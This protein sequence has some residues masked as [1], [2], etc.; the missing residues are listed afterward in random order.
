MFVVPLDICRQE[1][2]LACPRGLRRRLDRRTIVGISGFEI[3]VLALGTIMVP[4]SPEMRVGPLLRRGPLDG[5]AVQ[6]PIAEFK[7]FF[8][9]LRFVVYVG[10]RQGRFGGGVALP[11]D[12]RRD[13]FARLG[14][15]DQ[16]SQCQLKS[17]RRQ[18]QSSAE[19]QRAWLFRIGP[20]T[21]IA[22]AGIPRALRGG[23]CR[24][25]LRE[26]DGQAGGERGEGVFSTATFTPSPSSVSPR[27]WFCPHPYP[28]PEREGNRALPAISRSAAVDGEGF[29]PAP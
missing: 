29:A 2:G 22:R 10:Q 13:R 7:R 9:L 21:Q 14:H 24:R 11:D 3:E 20:P 26:A 25:P 1:H 15:V 16:A 5:R 27:A 8:I 28:L 6:E 17:C 12:F 4:C 19:E 23:R 18:P